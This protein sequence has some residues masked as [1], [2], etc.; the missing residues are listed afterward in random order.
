MV[1][2]VIVYPMMHFFLLFF[3]FMSTLQLQF[4]CRIIK[5]PLGLGRNPSLY[6]SFLSSQQANPSRDR[7][8]NQVPVESIRETLKIDPEDVDDFVRFEQN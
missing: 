8:I 5:P 7:W 4:L 3:W 6:D 2:L 1:F